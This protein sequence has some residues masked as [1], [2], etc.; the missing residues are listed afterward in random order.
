MNLTLD[1]AT[2]VCT[3]WPGAAE[4]EAACADPRARSASKKRRAHIQHRQ[5]YLAGSC[6]LVATNKGEHGRCEESRLE[7]RQNGPR[8]RQPESAKEWRLER[9]QGTFSRI[10]D[11]GGR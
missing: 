5:A 3:C 6:G 4:G 2:G 9:L 1:M 11:E 10:E 7:A 8:D